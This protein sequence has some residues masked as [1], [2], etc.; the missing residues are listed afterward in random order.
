V[1]ANEIAEDS[2]SASRNLRFVVLARAQ[3]DK[4]AAVARG[5]AGTVGGDALSSAGGRASTRRIAGGVGS[6]SKE[7]TSRITPSVADGVGISRSTRHDRRRKIGYD[8]A[9]APRQ[10]RLPTCRMTPQ[11][12]KLRVREAAFAFR[13]YDVNN[14]GRTPEL[15]A[16]AAYGPIVERYL[17]EAGEICADV[18]RRKVDLVRRV[19]RRQETSLKSYTDAIALVVGVEMAQ[20]RLL[21]EFFGINYRDAQMVYGYSLG[22]V[23]AVISAGVMAM[24]D[25]VSVPLALADDCAALAKDVTLGVLFSRG[26]EL[27][28]DDVRRLCLRV[29]NEG[30]GVIGISAYLS[31]NSVILL[32]QRKTVDRFRER[33]GEV[34]PE[35][36]NIRKNAYRWPPLHTPIVWEKF[37]PNRAGLL[38]HELPG[39]FSAP[40]PPVLSLVTG[41][42]SYN[43]FNAREIL[44]R[45]TDHPQR[46]WD[47]V[48][49]TLVR[50]VGTVVHVGPH[51]N[52]IPATF[53]RLSVNVQAQTRG[54]IGMQALSRMVSRPWLAAL[55]PRKTSLLRAPQM[56]H[57]ILEDWLLAQEVK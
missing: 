36:I 54:S 39:G 9:F 27:P 52:I 23:A 13:G 17:R 33:L 48:Q 45:W 55:L 43:D 20:L 32:G 1:R 25:A 8:S 40:C 12:L 29:N 35:G 3:A 26:R 4:N 15:L 19:R 24:G 42:T 2:E 28:M 16:H 6:Y 46:L 31:P 51:P 21:N 50:G 5:P 41:N 7:I 44:C 34:L 53:A 56:Q 30:K 11:Q 14:L 57:V 38:M 22:E 10:P 18:T 49:E 47:A 37:V